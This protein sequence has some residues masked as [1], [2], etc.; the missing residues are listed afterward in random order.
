MTM[1]TTRR[2]ILKL[3]GL[4]AINAVL[5]VPQTFAAEG[6]KI[7]AT[8]A[9]THLRFATAGTGS[10]WYA[11]GGAFRNVLLKG[12]PKGS[13][14]D[15]MS[16]PMAIANAFLVSRHEADIGL[17][18]PPVM[19]WAEKGIG[20]FK[21]PMTNIRG[22]MGGLDQYWQRV[23][24]RKGYVLEMLAD[25]KAKKLPVRIGT[26]PDGSL[27]EYMARLLLEAN[28]ITYA[29]IKSYGGN[30]TRAGLSVISDLF[31]D[32]RLD[33]VVGITTPG[34]PNTAQLSIS[35]GQRF[36]GLQD[37]AIEYLARYGFAPAT[38][39][40]GVFENQDQ[41][42]QGVG[43]KSALYASDAMSNEVAYTVCKVIMAGAAELR[44]SMASMKNWTPEMAA[45]SSKLGVAMH[46]GAMAYF[47]EA[48]LIQS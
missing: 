37:K 6:D 29:D 15:V 20:P 42:V 24:V 11:M 4:G 43:W 36:L 19:V 40:A 25:I 27:N 16:T 5:G 44:N 45:D 3:G 10:N 39:P 21:K 28:D 26:G 8:D 34:H 38:M 9:P 14:V 48:G 7:M 12:L 35:P 41:P 17:G 46:P 47:R 33:M 1:L 22:L 23:T 32:N 13:A 2:T 31:Q 18:F 30:V